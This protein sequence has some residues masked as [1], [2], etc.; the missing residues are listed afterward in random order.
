VYWEVLLKGIEG[1]GG[2]R[3]T[4]V[5]GGR[6]RRIGRPPITLQ[7]RT[8]SWNLQPAAVAQRSVRQG[9]DCADLIERRL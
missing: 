9:L 2:R 4:T 1:R 6:S 3:A 8:R 5:V 7:T